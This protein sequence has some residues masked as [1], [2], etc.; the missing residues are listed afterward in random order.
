MLPAMLRSVVIQYYKVK[1]ELKGV[2][3]GTDDYLFYM[4][5]KEKLN[6][7]YGMTVEDPAKDTIEFI[8]GDFVPKDE[9]LE[10]LIARHNRS[11]FLSYAWG[12]WVTAWSRKRLA[13]GIDVVTHN[14][15]E[16]M[17]FIYSDTDSIK[18]TGDVDFTSYN[19][20]MEEQAT[21]WK[22]YAADR[23]GVVHFMGV[24][25]SEHYDLPNRFKT[26]GAKKYVLEDKDKRLHITIAGVNK[27]EGGKELE[28]I[29][30]FKEGFVF[31]KAGGTESVFNDHV[32]MVIQE[33]GHDLHI[34]DNVVIRDSSYTLGITAEY[35]AI[36]DGVMEIKYSDHDIDGLFK[37]KN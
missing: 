30:N 1:T 9:P 35:R 32:D 8:D 25:E 12:V 18:Y 31:R 37:V 33:D 13:D 19:R 21:R 29:E 15:R 24:Y 2:E 4:K 17:N 11:A 26:L 10:K 5:N 23:D 27:K 16:P 3:E 20:Q 22:A 28:K 34:T 7:T 14:G 6:S 36:L